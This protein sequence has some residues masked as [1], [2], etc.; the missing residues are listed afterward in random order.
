MPEKPRF[1]FILQA[2]QVGN[3]KIDEIIAQ[4]TDSAAN[5]KHGKRLLMPRPFTFYITA[6]HGAR[7]CNQFFQ[8]VTKTFVK[9]GEIMKHL[10]HDAVK[11]NLRNGCSLTALFAVI[12]TGGIATVLTNGGMQHAW[13][14][15]RVRYNQICSCS[16]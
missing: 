2:I 16:L 14:I 11:R 1:G 15:E 13:L 9:V 6:L 12:T 4:P 8:R 7:F 10:V 5:E 3:S